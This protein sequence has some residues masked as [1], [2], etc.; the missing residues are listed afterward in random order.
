MHSRIAAIL[1]LAAASIGSAREEPAALRVHGLF[2]D[3]MVLQRD[4]ACPVW[5]T[6]PAGASVRVSIAGQTRTATAG[7]DGRWSLKLEPMSAGGPHEMTVSGA[8]EIV[9]RD[10]LVGEVWVAAGGGNMD[11][12]LKSARIVQ[13]ESDEQGIG[14]LRFFQA[15]KAASDEPQTE[16]S[17]AWKSG[18]S[19]AAPEFSAVAYSFAR[20]LQRTLKVPVGILQASADESRADQWMPRR[21]LRYSRAGRGIA[22]L[23]GMRMTNYEQTLAQHRGSLL[24]AEEARRKGEAPPPVLPE[25]PR[26]DPVSDLYHA[27][28]LPMIPYGIRGAIYYQGEAELYLGHQ[29]EG[30]LAGLIQG[31]REDWGQGAFPFGFVQLA[32]TGPRPD[33]GTTSPWAQFRDAQRRVLSVPGTGMAVAIDLGEG[34]NPRPRNKEEVGRRLALWAESQVYGRDVVFAGPLYDSI[35]IEGDKVRVRFKNLGGG[36]KAEGRLRGFRLSGEF[37]I[38]T[39]ADAVIDGDSVVVSS[40]EVKWPAAVRYGW[41]DN[42]DCNL[43]NKE[44]LPASPFRS[45]SW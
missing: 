16:I 45:D 38:F 2:G 20:E 28:I 21:A 23:Y 3:G 44:G 31:W 41:A 7:A 19:D 29:Y 39:D 22:I 4:R 37:R 13:T 35:R 5:G 14:Q 25:P 18:R 17:G 6:G 11:L 26:P 27:R 34:E 40:P 24:R 8:E 15:P 42:P 36:L 1:A 43:T 12:P 32:N 9:F 10:V 30:L 33:P